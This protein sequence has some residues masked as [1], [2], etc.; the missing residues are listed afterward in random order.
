MV[1]SIGMIVKNEEKYLEECLTALK[2]I[3]DEL[4]SELIIADTGSTDRTVEIAKK[5][6]DNVFYFE[7]IK[8][9]SAA[10]NSTLEK[11]QG[12][13]YMFIDADEIAVDCTG[14][15]NF[16]KSGEY[17]KYNSATYVQRSYVSDGDRKRY[18][19]FRPLRAVKREAGTRFYKP[20]HELLQPFKMP[21]KHLDLTVDH[22]GYMFKGEDGV[23]DLAREKS[24]RNLELL[25]DELDMFESKNAEPPTNIYTQ[26]ADCYSIIQDKK[27][28]LKYIDM[29]LEK[30][31]HHDVA[32]YPYYSQK[33]ALFSSLDRY[34]EIIE[35]TDEIFDI[36]KNP[37]HTGDFYSDCYI[38]ATRGYAYFNLKEYRNAIYEYIK[39]FDL[40]RKYTSGRL[41]TN[42]ILM[43]NLRT[44][45]GIVKS[46]YNNFLRSCLVEGNYELA[47]DHSKSIRLEN[48]LD[49]TD[50]MITHLPLQAD[51][52]EKNGYDGLET[53]YKQLDDPCR[54]ILLSAVRRKII[55]TYKDH[56]VII[57]K[58]LKLGGVAAESA[59]IYKGYCELEPNFEL[60]KNFLEKYGSENGEDMLYILLEYQ[61]DISPFLL[62]EDFFAD[63]AVS[64]M[65]MFYPNIPAI[66]EKY[67]IRAISPYGIENATSL[68]GYMLLRTWEGLHEVTELFEKYGALG[69][70]WF[71]DFERTTNLPDDIRASLFVSAVVSA[72]IE[73]NRDK[74][75]LAVSE[76]K[77]YVPEMAPLV[78][79]YESENRTAF[80]AKKTNTEFDRLAVRV[81]QNI[82]DL[83]AIGNIG[84]ARKLIKEYEGIAPNDPEIE[85]LK[86]ELNNSLQ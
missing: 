82:R 64:I 45:D 66:Y 2:P 38:R 40:Y 18:T 48:Y 34:D 60:I 8:D 28:A 7:W 29:G 77:K 71:N 37:F 58:L 74:F 15:I 62:T 68:Y 53:L 4:D 41:D 52:M 75:E 57:G 83:I 63:R 25:L 86:D 22:Y 54:K 33:V 80:R 70:K 50:F 47:I 35:L 14:I 73:G 3:L 19:D 6:T 84:E 85:T 1:L 78:D 24:E 17:K 36:E 32:V 10:R 69:L 46:V 81:K 55:S 42:D 39:F 61:M 13:W 30:V 59:E 5:F 31:D 21:I 9:F 51:I 43:D 65:K 23:T 49:D 79:E 56:D 11:A 76:L 16:F 72:K 12:E 20:V 27:N 67:D 26:I 44:T